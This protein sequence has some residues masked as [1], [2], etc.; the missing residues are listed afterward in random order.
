VAFPFDAQSLHLV[1]LQGGRVVGCVLFHPESVEDGRL[2]QMAVLPSRQ[3]AGLGTRLV[4]ALEAE[5]IRRGFRSV[6]LHARA[7]VVPFYE[8]LGYTVVGDPFEEVGV[9]HRHMR[10]ALSRGDR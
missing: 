7:Q 9:P 5:L 10:R 4:R 2:Y 1:A 3:R 8:R 6:H